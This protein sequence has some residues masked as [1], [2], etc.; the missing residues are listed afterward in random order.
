MF[1]EV[2]TMCQALLEAL[3]SYLFIYSLL[4]PFKA[5]LSPF[6]GDAQRG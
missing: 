6:I 5:G 4:E 2:L 1:T 3:Y